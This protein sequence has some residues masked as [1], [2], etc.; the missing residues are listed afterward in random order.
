[1]DLDASSINYFGQSFGGGYGAVLSAVSPD[2]R[3]AVLNVPVG[4][5]SDGRL[6]PGGGLTSLYLALR[7]PSLLNN[8]AGFVDDIPLRYQPVKIRTTPGS[9][10]IQD[11][12]ERMDWIEAM[13]SPVTLAEHIKQ[14]TLPGQP[15]K[16]VLFQI[17]LGDQTVPNPA[18]SA[19]IRAAYLFSQVTLYRYDIA[20]KIDPAL[21][22]NP[23]TFLIPLGDPLQTLVGFAALL[24]G[25]VYLLINA[26]VVPDP[27][28]LVQPTVGINLFET[29]LILPEQ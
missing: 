27:N 12:F 17:A 26:D 16:R 20:K 10:A 9:G 4:T 11:F 22:D 3:A 25:F 28:V 6:S 15:I 29:P 19:L 7:Q 13:S 24:Q 14:A 1:V 5:Q 23:H 8:G 21:P 2:L 18:Q